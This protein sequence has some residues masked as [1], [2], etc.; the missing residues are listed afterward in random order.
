MIIYHRISCGISVSKSCGTLAIPQDIRFLLFTTG[1]CVVFL[2]YR[3]L[4]QNI[5]V[6]EQYHRNTT[7]HSFHVVI[8][9]RKSCGIPDHF[10]NIVVILVVIS[11]TTGTPPEY[12]RSTTWH[13]CKGC[14]IKPY[15]ISSLS[16]RLT[17]Y[18]V[19]C[20]TVYST[21]RRK[22]NI[23]SLLKCK[24]GTVGIDIYI[25][26]MFIDVCLCFLCAAV[27]SY[28]TP[29]TPNLRIYN[30]DLP[31]W[32]LIHEAENHVLRSAMPLL[33]LFDALSDSTT[34]KKVDKIDNVLL[35]NC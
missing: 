17:L 12:L 34:P 22:W 1:N 18:Y 29:I 24:W 21:L 3:N 2:S 23:P 33:H 5:V 10:Q 15:E 7:E 16:S 20:N 8:Y 19:L 9:H 28:G 13:F 32:G 6:L 26:L 27:Y 14:H 31:T 11:N 30:L 25:P 35:T 4:F